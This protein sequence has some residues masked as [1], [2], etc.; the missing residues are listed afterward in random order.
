MTDVTVLDD[1]TL[2]TVARVLPKTSAPGRRWVTR[3]ASSTSKSRRRTARTPIR[4]SGHEQ[5]NH[6]LL[7]ASIC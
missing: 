1:G 4:A 7:R 2:V 6:P 3:R 5:R